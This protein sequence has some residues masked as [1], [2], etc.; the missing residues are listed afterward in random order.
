MSR[1]YTVKLPL[2]TSGLDDAAAV[3]VLQNALAAHQPNTPHSASLSRPLDAAA[4]PG[5]EVTAY[6]EICADTNAEVERRAAAVL[7]A[8]SWHGIIAT[9][10]ITILSV[11]V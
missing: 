9:G 5:G 11:G 10:A 7:S 2:Q 8:I 6:L 1:Q 4:G 3:R